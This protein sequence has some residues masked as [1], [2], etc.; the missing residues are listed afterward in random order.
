MGW[1]SIID[2][3]IFQQDSLLTNAAAPFLLSVFLGY[4]IH[5]CTVVLYLPFSV[6]AKVFIWLNI[7]LSQ[8]TGVF[9]RPL[10]PYHS[11]GRVYMRGVCSFEQDIPFDGDP[12]T[13]KIRYVYKISI[14]PGPRDSLVTTINIG[15]LR[16]K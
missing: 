7:F 1:I 10:T 8:L 3:N 12:F 14:D 11:R 6:Y 9:Q 13:N 4:K 2:S 5:A 16:L 15:N